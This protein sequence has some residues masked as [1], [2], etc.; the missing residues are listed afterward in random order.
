MYS[1]KSDPLTYYLYT[2][3]TK[4]QIKVYRPE[5][6]ILLG[7]KFL[8]REYKG[9]IYASSV[10]LEGDY[11]GYK[12]NSMFIIEIEKDDLGKEHYTAKIVS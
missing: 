7:S 9:K 6:N 2:P 11:E 5:G 1:S 8:Y 12:Q 3:E 10:S 4:A